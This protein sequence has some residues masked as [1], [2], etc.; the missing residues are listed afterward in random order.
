MNA[1]RAAMARAGAGRLI[2]GAQ[3]PMGEF[4]GRGVARR[5]PWT[6]LSSLVQPQ[7]VD[8]AGHPVVISEAA[9]ALPQ[10]NGSG[11]V[12]NSRAAMS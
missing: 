5:G 11:M 3:R 6:S 9:N 4:G 7:V 12:R 8:E 1:W 2:V 10:M